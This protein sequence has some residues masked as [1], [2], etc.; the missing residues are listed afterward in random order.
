VQFKYACTDH[1]VNIGDIVL[2]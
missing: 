1:K 2:V